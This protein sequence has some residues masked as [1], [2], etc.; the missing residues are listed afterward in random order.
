MVSKDPDATKELAEESARNPEPQVTAEDPLAS[1]QEENA[2]LK[3]ELQELQHKREQDLLQYEQQVDKEH[4]LAAQAKTADQPQDERRASTRNVFGKL[5]DFFRHKASAKHESSLDAP[6][7]PDA[8]KRSRWCFPFRRR[9][10]RATDAKPDS[11]VQRDI[12]GVEDADV[13]GI[14]HHSQDAERGTAGR[15][16][17]DSHD[18]APQ[19]VVNESEPHEQVVDQGED[20]QQMHRVSPLE[21]G[22]ADTYIVSRLPS[23]EESLPVFVSCNSS[24]LLRGCHKELVLRPRV[25]LK[26][27]MALRCYRLSLKEQLKYIAYRSKHH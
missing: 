23:H 8:S 27:S 17:Q 9:K 12:S 4:K 6:Q 11:S 26:S 2:R 16:L 5:R 24:E 21:I 10:Q 19:Q 7:L 1:A 22:Q 14:V 25:I 15:Q 20:T 18:P 3:K 13:P